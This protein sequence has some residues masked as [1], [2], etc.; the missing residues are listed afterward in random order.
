[1]GKARELLLDNGFYAQNET[2]DCDYH[3]EPLFHASG[4]SYV[5]LHRR[6][7]YASKH[8]QLVT[9]LF[10]K[11][12]LI[13]GCEPTTGG[14]F[15][16]QTYP[17]LFLYNQIHNHHDFQ[18]TDCGTDMRYVSEQALL[19]ASFSQQQWQQ[20]ID[21]MDVESG[22][23]RDGF[24]IQNALV[25]DFFKIPV[26]VQLRY[27]DQASQAKFRRTLRFLLFDKWTVRRQKIQVYISLVP[28]FYKRLTDP[29]WWRPR[30][31]NWQWYKSRPTYLLQALRNNI[32]LD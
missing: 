4:D 10:D 32:P 31:L 3:I 13:K 15:Y 23:F 8:S 27:L 7:G 2:F 19:L 12:S 26:P 17:F 20:T 28:Y 25:H 14:N 21:L 30:V 18:M 11:S 1:M 5:E 9:Q 6:P 22:S 24:Y 29:Q 16:Y